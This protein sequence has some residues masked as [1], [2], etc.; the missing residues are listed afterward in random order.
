M[1]K[2]LKEK[3]LNFQ[4]LSMIES[5]VLSNLRNIQESICSDRLITFLIPFTVYLQSSQPDYINADLID[6]QGK[7][8]KNK[9][10]TNQP[11]CA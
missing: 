1:E 9:K 5:W 2:D 3:S 7:K 10:T 8:K 11:G 6:L 4:L